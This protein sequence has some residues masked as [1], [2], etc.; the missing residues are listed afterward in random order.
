MVG[1]S[2]LPALDVVFE[3][4]RREMESFLNSKGLFEDEGKA[5]QNGR[6]GLEMTES[7]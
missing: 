7:L 6:R 4:E 1:R 2:Q 5:V 3:N